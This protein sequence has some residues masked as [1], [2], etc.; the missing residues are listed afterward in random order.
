[1]QTGEAGGEDLPEEPDT[2][3]S[4]KA[5]DD[6]APND[7]AEALERIRYCLALLACWVPISF[8]IAQ[9]DP[10]KHHTKI[11]LIL[12]QSLALTQKYLAG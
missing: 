9:Y 1:M 12:P 4:E 6:E 11:P 10:Q 2:E 8:T 5:S 3:T 7:P